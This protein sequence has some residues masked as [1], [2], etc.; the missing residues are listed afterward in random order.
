MRQKP[1]GGRVNELKREERSRTREPSN[2]HHHSS[3]SHGYDQGRGRSKEASSYG[4][5]ERNMSR[6]PGKALE[7][8]PKSRERFEERSAKSRAKDVHS[9]SGSSTPMSFVSKNNS[10]SRKDSSSSSAYTTRSPLEMDQ[11]SSPRQKD[12]KRSFEAKTPKRSLLGKDKKRWSFENDPRGSQTSLEDLT[13]GSRLVAHSS[14]ELL[15]GLAAAAEEAEEVTPAPSLM[16]SLDLNH[17]RRTRDFGD[18]QILSDS[19]V[20]AAAS[21]AAAAAAASSR[22]RRNLDEGYPV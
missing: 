11:R 12:P 5:H 15:T 17:F 7:A 4:D 20:A 9:S 22:Q 19:P 3:S 8:S 13:R 10:R 16:P 18:F 2:D 21:P 1:Q 6:S 14:K